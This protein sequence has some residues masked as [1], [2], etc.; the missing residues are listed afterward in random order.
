MLLSE[1]VT[2]V[3]TITNRP[4]LVAET[5]LA[6]RRAT[7]R[8]H[9]CESFPKDIR[10]VVLPVS[11]AAMAGAIDTSLAPFTRFRAMK[12]LRESVPLPTGRERFLTKLEPDMLTDSYG[13]GSTNIWWL[14]GST[15]NWNV[16]YLS[17]SPSGLSAL[18]LGY[19][20]NPDTNLATYDASNS[21]IAVNEPWCIIEEASAKIL[22]LTGQLDVAN[23]LQQQADQSRFELIA[24]YL[25][26]QG[27]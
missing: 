21:W 18:E 9:G 23:A 12:W 13:I 20:Q 8:L 10:T 19:Y 26:G 17:T 1:L 3:M 16:A 4:D 15:I 2:S 27:R 22:R 14:A 11:P 24:S 25:E 6:I 5:N 7:Q